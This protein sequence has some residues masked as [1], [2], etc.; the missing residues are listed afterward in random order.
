MTRHKSDYVQNDVVHKTGSTL[1]MAAPTMQDDILGLYVVSEIF[2]RRGGQTDTH[3]TIFRTPLVGE[4]T[5]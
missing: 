3:I 4:V 1:L 5:K 2:E